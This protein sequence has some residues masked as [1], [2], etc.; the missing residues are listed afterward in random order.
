[1]TKRSANSIDLVLDVAGRDYK[2][3]TAPQHASGLT[4]AALQLNEKISAVR[5]R[6]RN[7]SNEQAAVLA[8][9]ELSYDLLIEREMLVQQLESSRL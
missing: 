1:M 9:L 5:Q 2:L 6:G 8:A 3:R 4:E 7:L